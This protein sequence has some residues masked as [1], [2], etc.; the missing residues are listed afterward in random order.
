MLVGEVVSTNPASC[1]SAATCATVLAEISP[2]FRGTAAI[3]VAEPNSTPVSVVAA[4]GYPAGSSCAAPAVRPDTARV[5][6]PNSTLP[7][8]AVS[9]GNNLANVCDPSADAEALKFKLSALL[10]PVS[11]VVTEADSTPAAASA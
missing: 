9:D 7:A 1:D 8:A 6:I 3:E 5:G 10:A 4:D 11:D 2:I